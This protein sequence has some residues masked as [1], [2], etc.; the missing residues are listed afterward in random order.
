[1]SE[2]YYGYEESNTGDNQSPDSS[3]MSFD[4][5]MSYGIEKGW[6]GPPLCSTHDGIPYSA[7]EEQDWEAGDD[8]CAHIIRLYNDEEHKASIEMVHAPTT[9]R[10]NYQK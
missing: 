3:T 1:M 6:C 4:E 8:P 10:N 7:E 9:W 2:V 5:W